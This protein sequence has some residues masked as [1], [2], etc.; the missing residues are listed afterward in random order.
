[1]RKRK[2]MTRLEKVNYIQKLAL[3]VNGLEKEEN[4]IRPYVWADWSGH[5][6][7]LDVRVSLDGDWKKEP[8]VCV[9]L[10]THTSKLGIDMWNEK[11]YRE[12]VSLLLKLKKEWC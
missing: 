4:S 11:T 5:V 8:D 3:E 2:K 9:G 1:M 7:A 12:L 10:Y 6:H